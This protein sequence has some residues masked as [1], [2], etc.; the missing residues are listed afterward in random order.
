MTTFVKDNV[1]TI[2]L[3][4]EVEVNNSNEIVDFIYGVGFLDEVDTIKVLIN[5]PGGSVMGG[6]SIFTALVASEKKVITQIDGIAA[7]IAAVIFM[8]GQER[9]MME[10][11]L[12]MIH[13]PFGGSDQN[14]LDKIKQSLMNIL[15]EDNFNNLSELMDEETWLNAEEMEG[16]INSIIKVENGE[17]EKVTNKALELFEI[18]NQLKKEEMENEKE[19]NEEVENQESSMENEALESNIEER[20]EA[21]E[22]A[23]EETVEEVVN[24]VEENNEE[25]SEEVEAEVSEEEIEVEDE[26]VEAVVEE[27]NV[28]T[29]ETE[30]VA[31][32]QAEVE[33]VE[34][35]VE[36]V[37]NVVELTNKLKEQEELISE[38]S[39][40]LAIYEK[41]A[42]D[43]AKLS[44]LEKSN[45]NPDSYNEW[46]DMDLE[47]I[48]R[49]AGTVN[50]VAPTVEST[51][52]KDKVWSIEEKKNLLK[53]DPAEYARLIR[54]GVLK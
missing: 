9:Y 20:I 3:N 30:A 15:G 27:E 50:K 42:S 39:N 49:L 12:F 25:I 10:Y 33:L 5:S 17:M 40:K 2:L 26:E 8:A 22:E 32:E 44:L 37:S 35:S 36:E 43:K 7:S 52:N 31:E 16:L 51:D 38:L 21:S 14:A 24:E 19:F 41:E 13:N 6:L 53:E 48:E 23:V 34:N 18:V 29:E 45:I 4:Q 28:E 1:A 11:G 47:V 46:M 54:T